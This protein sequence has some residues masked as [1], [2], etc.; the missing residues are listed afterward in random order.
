MS[1]YVHKW[2]R[3]NSDIWIYSSPISLSHKEEYH[4]WVVNCTLAQ[5]ACINRN[6]PYKG[7][8][9][10]KKLPPHRIPTVGIVRKSPLTPPQQSH[11]HHHPWWCRL[12]LLRC[13]IYGYSQSY[14]GNLYRRGRL[15]VIVK[16]TL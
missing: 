6:T 2:F 4:Q 16:I 11:K 8:G 9:G 10:N 3:Q 7:S 5:Y 1:G 12:P 14:A 15:R 13:G